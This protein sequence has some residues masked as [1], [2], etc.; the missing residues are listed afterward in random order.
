MSVKDMVVFDNQPS[1]YHQG[2][3]QDQIIQPWEILHSVKNAEH[4][5]ILLSS[6]GLTATKNHKHLLICKGGKK[7]KLPSLQ[8]SY[9]DLKHLTAS[10]IL[11]GVL[12]VTQ[13]DAG[14]CRT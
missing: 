10:Y 5:C 4:N 9:T 14:E 3:Y 1:V 12:L 6:N 2:H 8:T 11:S 13:S 7:K